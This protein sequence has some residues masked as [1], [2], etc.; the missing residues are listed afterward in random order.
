MLLAFSPTTPGLTATE[1]VELG[2]LAESLGYHGAWA[3]EVAGPGAFG[4][5]GAMAVRT[6]RLELGVAVVPAVTRSPALLAMEAATVSQL[7]AGRALWLG[8]G[9]SSQFIVESWHGDAFEPPLTRVEQAVMATRALLSGERNYTGSHVRVERFALASPPVGPVRLA[10]GALGPAMLGLAGAIG[11]GACLNLMPPSL[12]PRQREAIAAGAASAGRELP[13]HF[14]VMARLHT[15]PGEDLAA[16][17]D[18]VRRG[19]GPYFGQ[20]VYN[21]FLSWMGH[22][23]EAAAVATAFAAGDRDGVARAMT[24]QVVDDVALVGPI[25][26]IRERLADYGAAGLDVGALSIIAANATE[27]GKV[28]AALA[29]EKL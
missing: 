15:V 22:P 5:L 1:H 7:L 11:D 13:A 6:S 23:E 14:T 17:R 8:I 18:A 25:G 19:F 21:R 24:D 3:A 26:R 29:P 2:V 9:A 16:C 20:P 4:L 10:V 27:V 12:V 28:L